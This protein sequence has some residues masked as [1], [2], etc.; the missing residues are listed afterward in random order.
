[1]QEWISI[2]SKLH[3]EISRRNLCH[4]ISLLKKIQIFSSTESAEYLWLFVER[5]IA[6]DAS[7]NWACTESNLEWKLY[8]CCWKSLNLVF[9]QVLPSEIN[10]FWRELSSELMWAEHL[11]PSGN[12][13]L[14]LGS[15]QMSS[16]LWK[17]SSE[18]LYFLLLFVS[19]KCLVLWVG[20][21]HS[22]WEGLK[23]YEQ[24]WKSYGPQCS[25]GGGRLH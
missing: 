16:G 23:I 15:S 25:W 7:L 21:S 2:S 22:V 3:P 17:L 19:S 11:R 13:I 1:M 5:K 14:Y 12:I 8:V 4:L 24:L 10:F 20:L 18:L 6:I 9:R